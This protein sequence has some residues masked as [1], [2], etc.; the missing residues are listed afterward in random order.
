MVIDDRVAFVQS[1][2]WDV[3][4]LEGTRDYAVVTDDKLEVAEVIA[5]F[6]SRLEAEAVRG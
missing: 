5:G 1:L 4:N 6:R 2:N 3:K